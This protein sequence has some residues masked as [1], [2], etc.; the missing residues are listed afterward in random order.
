MRKLGWCVAALAF[1]IMGC[2]SRGATSTDNSSQAPP[3]ASA[4]ATR[5]DAPA[6]VEPP[7]PGWYRGTLVWALSCPGINP[8]DSAVWAGTPFATRIHELALPG[9]YRVDGRNP[10]RLLGPD[11]Q[12]LATEGDVIE[13][14][15]EI[16]VATS[17]FCSIGPKV[18]VRELRVVDGKV[19][20]DIG[21]TLT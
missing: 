5:Q 14:A 3:T 1:T 9:D 20:F 21:T 13:V 10:F 12:V 8:N 7:T 17:S 16:P 2:A 18:I 11:G 6:S 4:S 19:T 15:G